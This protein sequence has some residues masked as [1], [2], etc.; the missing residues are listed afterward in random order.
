MVPILVPMEAGIGVKLAAMVEIKRVEKH[1]MKE[2]KESGKMRTRNVGIALLCA[3][4]AA[5]ATNLS[6]LARG[7]GPTEKACMGPPRVP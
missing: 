3:I 6:A 1:F 2:R 7:T 4:A 5:S